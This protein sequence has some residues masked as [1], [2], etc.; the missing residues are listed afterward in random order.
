MEEK[1]LTDKND[2]IAAAK[3]QWQQEQQQVIN[4]H[5]WNIPVLGQSRNQSAFGNKGLPNYLNSL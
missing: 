3:K 2:N 5:F 4:D 1:L